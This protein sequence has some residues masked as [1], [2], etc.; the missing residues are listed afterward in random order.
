MPLNTSIR[1]RKSSGFDEF[2]SELPRMSRGIAVENAADYIVGND[3]HG[4]RHE[5]NYLFVSRT[6]AYGEPFSSEKQ[7]RWFFASLKAGVNVLNGKSFTP[8]RE[9]RDHTISQAWKRVGEKTTS[10]IINDA[11]GVEW[12]MGNKQANQPRKAGWR[13]YMDVV[14]S[15]F[16]GAIQKAQWAVDAWIR[17]KK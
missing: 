1:L 16:K 9:N 12:V 6:S 5:P 11:E 15:N 2:F 8:G 7:K 17:S 3:S 14:E 10:R 4:L 13:Y